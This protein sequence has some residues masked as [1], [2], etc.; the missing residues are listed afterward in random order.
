LLKYPFEKGTRWTTRRGG[1]SVIFFIEGTETVKVRAG[2]FANCLKVRE[3]QAGNES[4]W[5]VDYYAPGVGKVLTTLATPST[6]KRN[7]ELIS[8]QLASD[9]EFSGSSGRPWDFLKKT[10]GLKRLFGKPKDE[11]AK[12]T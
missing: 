12:K 11:K 4:S 3:I 2:E 5:K 10:P 9:E 1:A 6:E 7:T 8:Y